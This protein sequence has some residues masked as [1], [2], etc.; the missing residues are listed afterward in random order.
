MGCHQN[1]Q[2][3]TVLLDRK[4]I[5]TMSKFNRFIIFQTFQLRC[6]NIP[7][8]SGIQPLFIMKKGKSR[9]GVMVHHLSNK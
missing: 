9:R 2:N 1:L 3:E 4:L 5:L 7:V 8:F 6:K